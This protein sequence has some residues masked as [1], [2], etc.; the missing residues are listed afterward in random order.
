MAFHGGNPTGGETAQHALWARN[1]KVQQQ[2]P[3]GPSGERYRAALLRRNDAMSSAPKAVIALVSRTDQ[4]QL[5]RWRQAG[6][7]LEGGRWRRS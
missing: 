2:A 3:S 1:R 6:A 7:D 5:R 4:R